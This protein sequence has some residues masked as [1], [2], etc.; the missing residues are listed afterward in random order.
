MA[1]KKRKK[2]VL[3]GEVV[4]PSPWR[5]NQNEL[6]SEFNGF[7][8]SDNIG[9]G[10]V[11]AK[12]VK[13]DTFTKVLMNHRFAQYAYIFSH[14][15]SGW[16]NYADFLG[17]EN[18]HT[19]WNGISTT[20]YRE[21]IALKGRN[22]TSF[23]ESDTLPDNKTFD[24]EVAT[25]VSILESSGIDSSGYD[26]FGDYPLY[27]HREQDRDDPNTGRNSN[28]Q[29]YG[30]DNSTRMPF[31]KFRADSDSMLITEVSF[32][33]SWLPTLGSLNSSNRQYKHAWH[34]HTDGHWDGELRKYWAGGIP[35][36]FEDVEGSRRNTSCFILCSQFRITVDGRS[37]AKTGFIGP[38]LEHHPVY[39]TGATPISAGDHVTQLEARF[40]WYNPATGKSMPSASNDF[41]FKRVVQ[42][43]TT[44]NEELW[45]RIDC[46]VRHPNFIVQIRSR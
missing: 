5:I 30:Y 33:V 4:E 16:C 38:E 12:N 28:L 13:R 40:V 9:R 24:D 7:L 17:R 26:P 43:P 35:Y 21:Q 45:L 2:N 20:S 46:S 41:S 39:L 6:A 10:S 22:R 11:S 15:Q 27:R 29:P 14:Q 42:T 3:D 18:G 25:I 23:L 31:Y 32:N 37:V 34:Y 36:K 1:W 19:R 8:D 44:D